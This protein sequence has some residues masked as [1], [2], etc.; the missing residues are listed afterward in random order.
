[1]TAN[2]FTNLHEWKT[3]LKG[4]FIMA[5]NKICL[6]S[7]KEIKKNENFLSVPVS[8]K[9]AQGK[10]GF[11]ITNEIKNGYSQSFKSESTDKTSVFVKTG[12]NIRFSWKPLPIEY[13]GFLFHT[14]AE[15]TA[16]LCVITHGKVQKMG[17]VGNYIRVPQHTTLCGWRYIYTA[18]ASVVE[19]ADVEVLATLENDDMPN[20]ENVQLVLSGCE[21]VPDIGEKFRYDAKRKTFRF[22]YTDIASFMRC[23]DTIHRM[24]KNSHNPIKLHKILEQAAEHVTETDRRGKV[25]KDGGKRAE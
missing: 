20:M 17:A 12:L 11:V 2:Y 1:M 7:G 6:L 21:N 16:F 25:I 5:R 3:E 24:M 15:I 10:T 22:T 8:Y 23:I 14:E 18:V 13:N 9:G 19:I 4:V